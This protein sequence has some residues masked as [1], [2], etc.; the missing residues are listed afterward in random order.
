MAHYIDCDYIIFEYTPEYRKMWEDKGIHKPTRCIHPRLNDYE[1]TCNDGLWRDGSFGNAL[2]SLKYGGHGEIRMTNELHVIK[3]GV[4][5][6][7]ITRDTPKEL[8]TN[9]EAA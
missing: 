1:S 4:E 2:I 8:Y 3:D 7:T 6:L 9:K 5:I